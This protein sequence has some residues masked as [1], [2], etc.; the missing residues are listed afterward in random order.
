LLKKKKNTGPHLHRLR[1]KQSYQ[2]GKR[3]EMELYQVSEAIFNSCFDILPLKLL[4]Q[5]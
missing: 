2:L 3:Q 4:T 5:E 1:L